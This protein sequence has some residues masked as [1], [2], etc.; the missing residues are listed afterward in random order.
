MTTVDTRASQEPELIIAPVRRS[1]LSDEAALRLETLIRDGTF[2]EGTL[3]P[4]E[5]ELMKIFQVGRASM[6]E[7]LYALGRMGL[8]QVRN[9][10]R[11]LV[12][13]PKPENLITEFSGAARYLLSQ[14]NG[15][16]HFQEARALL[17]VGVARAAAAKASD[18]DIERL[19]RALDANAAALSD[20]NRFERTDVAFHY[21]LA[22]ITQNP[23][24]T[25][26]HDALVEWLTHQR[27]MTVRTPGAAEGALA[28]HRQI[29]AAVSARNPDAAA[30]AMQDH[31]DEVARLIAQG[32]GTVAVTK[33]ENEPQE[34]DYL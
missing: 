11:P 7:A 28:Y 19:K 31:L 4:S 26:V 29:F 3:L 9:G 14:P 6:R 34:L 32:D 18:E 21:V 33:P 23:I 15:T 20:L 22:R 30:K 17:E 2:P 13:R 16:A 24:F 12:T 8:I 27:T 1:R 25:A 5:R 10:E